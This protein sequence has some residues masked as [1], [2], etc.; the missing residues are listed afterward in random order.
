MTTPTIDSTNPSTAT[1]SGTACC[2][3][4]DSP[5][6]QAPGCAQLAVSGQEGH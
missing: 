6:D 1:T 3:A 4:A 2:A 5:Q